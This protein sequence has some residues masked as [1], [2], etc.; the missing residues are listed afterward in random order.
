MKYVVIELGEHATPRHY[1][2]SDEDA[3][4]LLNMSASDEDFEID[5]WSFGENAQAYEAF[6][7]F[8]AFIFPEL[9]TS[10]E[11]EPFPG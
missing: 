5:S 11:V 1:L 8:T 10:V 6:K 3:E 9:T 7:G 2:V 4:R